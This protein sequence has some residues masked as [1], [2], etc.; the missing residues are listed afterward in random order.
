MNGIHTVSSRRL[1]PLYPLRAFEAAARQMSFTLAAK[2]LS[3]SQSAVSHQVKSLETYFGVPL[4]YRARGSIRLTAEGRRLF[5]AC[6]S[7]FNNLAQ[8]STDLPDSELRDTL[9]LSSP[10]LIFN[11]WLLPQLGEFARQH[12]NIR[13]R[14]QHLICGAPIQPA[15]TDIALLWDTKIADGFVGAKMFD[16]DYS[17]VTSPRLAASLPPE[18]GPETLGQTTLLHEIDHSGWSNWLSNAGHPELATTSGWV[19]EDPGM[20]IEAA[21]AGQGVALGPFPLLDEMVGS[22]RLVRP[23]RQSIKTS[24]SYYMT[25]STRSLS[26]PGIKLF[27]NW[28]SQHGLPSFKALTDSPAQASA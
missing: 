24:D 23:F 1:P 14:F 8:I 2:E 4:F 3:I 7:A 9:T 22:G 12:P 13:F 19:F 6:E 16:M 5:N 21:A 28:F 25:V 17:P 26:K 15:D 20:M 27:W 18:F 11:W 10:P